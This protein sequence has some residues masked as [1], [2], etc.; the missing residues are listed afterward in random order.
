MQ[1]LSKEQKYKLVEADYAGVHDWY[2]KTFDT[3]IDYA[4]QLNDFISTIPADA[5]VL[6]IGSG[7]GKEAAVISQ[8]AEVIAL[9]QSPDM[10]EKINQRYPQVETVLGDMRQMPFADEEFDS[11]WSCS[12]IIHIVQEDLDQT[13][14]EYSRVLK[15]EGVIGLTFIAPKDNSEHVEEFIPEEPPNQHLTYY[16]N[17]YSADF[18]KARLERTGFK[19]LKTEQFDKYGDQYIY[20][21]LQ[22]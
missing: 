1:N 3:A 12:S 15:P 17:L 14:Q 20:M 9:D 22:K 18:M 8:K 5:K 10:I 6:D 7:P 21:R 2:D 13:L 4:E 11:I 19:V 16:R